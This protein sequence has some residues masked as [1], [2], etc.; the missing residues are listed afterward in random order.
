MTSEPP[1]RMPDERLQGQLTAALGCHQRGDLETARAMYTRILRDHPRCFD[2]LHLLGV[3]SAATG[4]VDVGI[5]LL[6][7]AL[8]VE[9]SNAH[10]HYSLAT[11]L[12]KKGDDRSALPLLDRALELQPDFA[13]AWFLRGK[14]LQQLELLNEAVDS[15]RQATRLRPSFPEAFNN[16]A[17]AY[18]G[19]RQL[20]EALEC[21]D[22]ALAVQ[23][24][25]PKAL[26]NRGLILLDCLRGAAAVE[27]FRRA[28]AIDRYFP[29]ALHNLGT[30][31]MQLRR[32]AE[33][34][35]AFS[36]LAAIAPKFPHALGNRLL[37]Q[38]NGC[39]WSGFEESVDAV[40]R[41]VERGEHAAVPM[42]FLCICDSAALQRRC[43]TLYTDAFYPPR[44][45]PSKRRLHDSHEKIRVAYLSGDLGE[46]AI[47][48]LL[49][50]VFE[51]HDRSCF[52]TIALSW[53]RRDAGPARRRVEA[54]FS[55]FIDITTRDDAQVARLMQE[56]EVDIAVDLSGH[57]LGQ[58]TG[59]LAR[60]PAPVQVNYL[61]LPAT[62]GAPYVDYLIADRFLVP[63]DHQAHYAERVVWLP[64][65]FQ[66]NDDRR[67]RPAAAK[68][69]S[70]LGL[71]EDGFVFC[72]FNRGNK[73]NPACFDVWMG[74]IKSV[75]G[76][77]LWLLAASP[78]AEENLRREAAARGVVADRLVFAGE[79]SYGDYLARY[80]CADLLLD[81][82]PFNG[83]T[84]VSDAVSMG[85]PVLTCA[86]DS[87]AARMAG[88]I[89]TSL[90]HSQLVT[91]SLEEYA[92][93][94]LRLAANPAS[95]KSLRKRLEGQ[96]A[97]HAFFN[98]DRYRYHLEAAYRG[99][100]ERN[101]SG[102][103]PAAFSV[104]PR[105]S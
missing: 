26:N 32:F 24:A 63:P 84:T 10:A 78:T 7:E 91:N 22:S 74:V 44:A 94:A 81:T 79:V 1:S 103:P 55:R 62:M 82:L 4:A 52:E 37:A 67:P 42:L 64:D 34:R 53:D 86:G 23:P 41:A 102:L 8:A 18:R 75:P 70:A 61:G 56:L 43:A 93:A 98:T 60:R 45:T 3:L 97:G 13:D 89:L 25:Y 47:T 5:E 66:P 35:D 30:A 99:M 49:A 72:S 101:A 46:H 6:R 27:D 58:R 36:Q 14:V 88:S 17:A 73:L 9:P 71:P 19:L 33:A 87:F 59:I 11:A 69:R 48:Y 2:A 38:L 95:L 80:A 85:L 51:R 15:Y 12:L 54:A 100:W 57:T 20:S 31:L 40:I 39:D 96:R 16:L 65:S 29:E 28:V 50:G 92:A 105:E 77:V 21:A 83:G 76:S 68:P 90:G 104:A